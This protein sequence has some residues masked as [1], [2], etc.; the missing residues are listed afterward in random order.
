MKEFYKR[1]AMDHREHAETL[2]SCLAKQHGFT[3][4]EEQLKLG[5]YSFEPKTVIER[6]T[7]HDFCLSITGVC[8]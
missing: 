5:D 6:K 1:I 8:T 7:T 2:K 4:V 3:V